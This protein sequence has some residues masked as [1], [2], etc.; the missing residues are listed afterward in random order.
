MGNWFAGVIGRYPTKL[1]V[2][3]GCLS[4]CC[5]N[6]S[7]GETDIEESDWFT[8]DLSQLNEPTAQVWSNSLVDG[9]LFAGVLATDGDEFEAEIDISD[10]TLENGVEYFAEIRINTVST[11]EWP[12]LKA[13]AGI[14]V[15]W[16]MEVDEQ[17]ERLL[18]NNAS[19]VR[20]YTV[21]QGGELVWD[22]VAVSFPLEKWPAAEYEYRLFKQENPEGEGVSSGVFRLSK[23]VR[24]SDSAV[25]GRPVILL[26]GQGGN[27]NFFADG[28]W[29]DSDLDDDFDDPDYLGGRLAEGRP[30]YT[31][32]VPNLIDLRSMADLFEQAASIVANAH[33]DTK[34]DVLTHGVAG[35]AVR[36]YQ[37]FRTT[38]D[39][40]LVGRFVSL[41]APMEGTLARGIFYE[42]LWAVDG[43]LARVGGIGERLRA[44]REL[45]MSEY[46]LGFDPQMTSELIDPQSF[47][48]AI[49]EVAW[50]NEDSRVVQDTDYLAVVG[51]SPWLVQSDLSGLEDA[52]GDVWKKQLLSDALS[53]QLASIEAL[54]F[55]MESDGVTTWAS[56]GKSPVDSERNLYVR[57]NHVSYNRDANSDL[58]SM[59]D[60]IETF[61]SAGTLSPSSVYRFA[62]PREDY[63]F[64]IG[65]RGRSEI[66]I[67]NEQGWGIS[68][69]Y[70]GLK[71]A[72]ND[73]IRVVSTLSDRS[74]RLYL[75]TALSA[76]S[77]TQ[78]WI[79]APGYQEINIEDSSSSE[80]VLSLDE[81][82]LGAR[83][84]S[85]LIE[86]GSAS[87]FANQLRLDIAV[88]DADEMRIGEDG[89]WGAW[90]P[91][92]SVAS[93]QLIDQSAGVKHIQIEFRDESIQR[94]VVAVDKVVHGPGLGGTATLED[95]VSGAR[96]VFNGE[97]LP[98]TTPIILD[99][100][101]AGEYSLSIFRPGTIYENPARKVIVE[102]GGLVS[103]VFDPAEVSTV[104][105]YGP[106]LSQYLSAEQLADAYY[107]GLEADPDG[108]GLTNNQEYL[109]LTDPLDQDSKL[110][111]QWIDWNRS[112][113]SYGPVTPGVSPTLS[114][115]TDLESWAPVSESRISELGS[116]YR[117]DLNGLP[118]TAFYRV[119]IDRELPVNRPS[120]FQPIEAGTFSMGSSIMERDRSDNETSHDVTLT[121][122]FYMDSNE[123]TNASMV[124]VFNWAIDNEFVKLGASLL[125]LNDTMLLNLG[126]NE[127]RLLVAGEKLAVQEGFDEHPAV[128]VTWYG[129]VAYAHFRSLKEGR[130][131]GLRLVDWTY[132]FTAS[133]YRLPTE[134]EWEY[135]SRAGTDTA[136]SSGDN[137]A[138]DCDLDVALSSV[139]WY[140]FN[141]GGDTRK[142]GQKSPNAWG[143][144]DMHGNAS[145][146]CWDY[147]VLD[148]GSAGLLNP[149]AS[150]ICDERVARG[151]S[152]ASTV[153]RSR[154]AYR[155]PMDPDAAAR[156]TGFRLV[157]IEPE[158]GGN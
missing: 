107:A 41:G 156:T 88:E 125:T 126:N 54:R 150:S 154:S 16:R 96:V 6:L 10:V 123:T 43:D 40:G 72:D 143:L 134:S 144:Y 145:E 155:A 149:I 118:G 137:E 92:A 67:L 146:W 37:Y 128:G 87:S 153:Q 59:V 133:G 17:G 80:V 57:A 49:G 100:L 8:L 157:L 122:S 89:V 18:L 14:N 116:E 31:L 39:Y 119:Q 141:S 27:A 47:I 75:P 142:V 22:D 69:A 112:E 90:T 45:G 108:D 12:E 70:V 20:G 135:A 63:D 124:E 5:V 114:S 42:E 79:Y 86:R 19:E 102:D 130:E 158:D 2:A 111:L 83:N 25:A 101:P 139:G 140:C 51:Y 113:L 35:V 99:G 91:V 64:Q 97:L 29:A 7:W 117:A 74:G 66:R 56:G 46:L 44:L 53:S 32:E 127:D 68:G 52:A 120:G 94:G 48:E 152:F 110:F 121:E 78:V 71:T 151:G 105:G 85:V 26:H 84:A 73:T 129:A 58:D 109:S 55:Q 33:N 77:G 76:N 98:E 1:L 148:W 132:D 13:G 62:P 4:L 11:T 36:Y 82:S 65:G 136:F 24:R 3:G 106:W 28:N 15:A 50:K 81:G 115:S 147:Y 30:T 9:G 34:V 104:S 21:T 60:N 38:A 138:S 95:M 131:S 23:L 103:L 93:H 61:F